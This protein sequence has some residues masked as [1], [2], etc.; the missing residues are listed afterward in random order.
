MSSLRPAGLGPIVGHTTAT[1]ARIWIRADPDTDSN[2]DLDSRTRTVGVLAVLKEDGRALRSK[3]CYYFRLRREFDRSGTINLGVDPGTADLK[4]DTQYVLRAGTLL[5]DD[6]IDDDE[7]ADWDYL[8]SRLPPPRAWLDDLNRLPADKA[9]ASF[10]TFPEDTADRLDF[11]LGSCRY[12]GLMW[13]IRHSDR[14]FEPMAKMGADEDDPSPPRF[15]LMVGDQIYAD[16]FHRSIPLGRAD[17][18]DEFRER[19][20]TAFGS[21]HIRSLMRQMPTYMILDDHEIE[22]NWTQDRLRRN[23]S[24]QLFT[25]AI[26]AYLSYQ[27]SHGPRNFGKRLYY[28]FD[29]GDYP[30][31]VLDTRTQRYLEG[32]DGDLSDNH[33]LGRPTLPGS[34]PG[35]LQR[36]LNWLQAQ[37]KHRGNVPKFIVTSSVFVPSS[38][39]ARFEKSD[40]EKEKGDSWPGF[41]NTKNAIL[42]C[43]VD[44]GIQNVVFLSGDIHCANVAK[45]TIDVPAQSAPKIFHTVTSSAFYW[46][47]PFADG[48]PS[49]FVHDSKAEGQKDTHPF[50][51]GDGTACTLDYKAWNFTQEDNFCRLSIDRTS[52]QLRVRTYDRRGNVVEEEDDK[53]DKRSLDASLDLIPW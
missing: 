17:T 43:L 51:A 26:D 24:H 41:P 50:E 47:F 53:G 27:W 44:H 46:P 30:F 13:K 39:S 10:S 11:L 49:D 3:P 52:H 14:I 2:R 35:Q 48:E 28:T 42:R 34:P 25:I 15:T 36:L 8:Q 29:V 16:M 6:P 5:L 19:Y 22:D 1:S 18:Y 9:E 4:P 40:R 20:L 38:M 33:M 45:A 31:F 23:A 21:R 32:E 7:G 12:P 37:Q